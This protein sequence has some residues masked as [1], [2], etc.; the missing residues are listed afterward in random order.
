MEKYE[1]EE[2]AKAAAKKEY[3]SAVEIF[4]K[5][6]CQIQVLDRVINIFVPDQS[7][8]SGRMLIQYRW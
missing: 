8:R 5:G 4:G 2:V 7:E 6:N 3:D 1:S